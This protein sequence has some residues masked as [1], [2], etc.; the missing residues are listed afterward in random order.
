MGLVK[1]ISFFLFMYAESP[2]SRSEFGGDS[3]QE[4]VKKAKEGKRQG[5]SRRIWI[6][7]V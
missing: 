5:T 7:A 1:S 3:H 4:V 6:D 2:A